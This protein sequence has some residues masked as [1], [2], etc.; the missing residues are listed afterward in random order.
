MRP[1]FSIV[2][3]LSLATAVPAGA[4][5]AVRPQEEG[6]GL[7]IEP[8]VGFTL[9]GDLYSGELEQSVNGTPTGTGAFTSSPRGQLS[10]G[11]R[12]GYE[13]GR[14]SPWS[15][16]GAVSF[17]ASSIDMRRESAV[18]TDQVTADLATWQMTLGLGRSLIRTAR[19]HD[20]RLLAGANLAQLRID[21]G[22]NDDVLANPGVVAGLTFTA[23]LWET[24]GIELSFAD[25]YVR[26]DTDALTRSLQ[27]RAPAG[28]EYHLDEGRWMNVGRIGVGVKVAY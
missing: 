5:G 8:N 14:G 6:L 10:Y 28:V 21:D 4:Q 26:V 3:S 12:A 17:G 23:P 24:V 13:F 19:G 9:F 11:L 27:R 1:F 22:T 20:F 2:I 7:T 25:S 18:V 16:F 15:L